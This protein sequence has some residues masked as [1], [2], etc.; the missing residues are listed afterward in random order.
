MEIWKPIKNYEGIYEISNLG[1]VKSLIRLKKGVKNITY[2]TKEKILKQIFDKDGYCM[3]NLYKNSKLK[4][5]KIHRL[6]AECF[7]KNIDNKKQVNHI[8]GIKHDNRLENLELISQK[9]NVLHALKLG[10]TKVP[11]KDFT[12]KPDNIE[13]L[14][15]EIVD[16]YI[17]CIPELTTDANKIAIYNPSTRICTVKQI[18]VKNNIVHLTITANDNG[19]SE[20][21]ITG[22]SVLKKLNV[23]V[24]Y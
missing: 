3:I 8:N 6:V 22:G 17:T 11:I 24:N 12:I 13:M 20:I 5:F 21:E 1:R 18:D 16:V 2:L 9:E 7:I 10:L 19:N 4:T 14:V 23:V 15:G